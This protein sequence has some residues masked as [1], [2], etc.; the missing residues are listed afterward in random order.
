M[1]K[2]WLKLDS[3]DY[4]YPEPQM[5]VHSLPS[6]AATGGPW[7]SKSEQGL[8]GWGNLWWCFSLWKIVDYDSGQVP[9][10]ASIPEDSTPEK[11]QPVWGPCCSVLGG[12]SHGEHAWGTTE[13]PAL[14]ISGSKLQRAQH[15]VDPRG[16]THGPGKRKEMECQALQLGN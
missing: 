11:V 16:G 2:L 1:A 9:L 13:R 15:C 14:G 7:S 8:Q 3:K 4:F 12:G 5:F 6:I 10:S